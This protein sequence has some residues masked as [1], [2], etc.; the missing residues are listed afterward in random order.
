MRT[1]AKNTVKKALFVCSMRARRDSGHACAAAGMRLRRREKKSGRELKPIRRDRAFPR[2]G[3][4]FAQTLRT[5]ARPLRPSGDDDDG[6]GSCLRRTFEHRARPSIGVA[7]GSYPVCFGC[8]LATTRA[9]DAALGDDSVRAHR[10]CGCRKQK[11]P[12]EAAVLFV[13]Y[14]R[15][16][17]RRFPAARRS[18]PGRAVRSPAPPRTSRRRTASLRRR[19]PR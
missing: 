13:R 8:R 19:R 11:R 5:I 9:G 1:H 14:D 3:E 18:R 17:G 16:S 12:H 2:R 7:D 4:R 10:R 15:I 6:G